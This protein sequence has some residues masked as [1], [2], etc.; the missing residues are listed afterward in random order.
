MRLF[1]IDVTINYPLVHHE[2]TNRSSLGAGPRML[3][4]VWLP[5]S[6]CYCDRRAD[7]QSTS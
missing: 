5:C 2:S 7:F 4:S 6:C 1:V 3:M